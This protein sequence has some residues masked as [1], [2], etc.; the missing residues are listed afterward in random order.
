MSSGEFLDAGEQLVVGP[1]QRTEFQILPGIQWVSAG[2]NDL[3]ITSD[4]PRLLR[5]K[6]GR[7]LVFAT[8]DAQQFTVDCNGL[9][10]QVKFADANSSCAIE[11]TN[12][13]VPSTEK[14]LT[15]K[16]LVVWTEVTV[17]GV[18]GKTTVTR[19][20]D[21]T[22]SKSSLGDDKGSL[23]IV[24]QAVPDGETELMEFQFYRW[25]NQGDFP[26][27]HEHREIPWWFR[28]SIERPID[29]MAVNDL[30]RSLSTVE[31]KDPMALLS[32]LASDRQSETA[33]IAI[34]TRIATGDY[35]NLFS[36]DGAFNR[37]G[38]HIQW[39]PILS[40]LSQSLGRVENRK[41]LLESI[42][43]D[44]PGRTDSILFLLIPKSQ[45]QLVAGADKLLVESLSSSSMDERVLAIHQLQRI[46]GK[47]LG[48]QPDKNYAEAIPAWRKALSRNEIRYSA[49]EQ[50]PMESTNLK[51]VPN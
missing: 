14:Q 2:E 30:S 43:K 24:N 34:R 31:A 20:K 12:A 40:Q 15:E 32:K 17:Y 6:S 48:Y 51:K 4:V 29:Q 26:S 42:Q 28:T 45:E 11:V 38:F 19:M 27:K 10:F 16:E 7:S 49:G 25:S 47:T 35:S 39:G 18:L 21:Q 13:I 44:I 23:A 8:P 46:T 5:L 22:P 37:K 50:K 9:P 36:P 33:A 1:A 41:K 3:E